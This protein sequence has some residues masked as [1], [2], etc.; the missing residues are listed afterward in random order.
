MIVKNEQERLGR[1]LQSVAAVADQ[2]VVVDTGSDDGT[3]QIAARHGAE[4]YEYAWREDFSAARNE[5]ISHARHEWILWLDADDVVPARSAEQ[6]K[7]LKGAHPDRVL[8]FIVRNQKP[9]D[10]G[11]EFVQARMFP[12]H[13]SLFFEGRIHEQIMPSA[14]RIGM[15]MEKQPVIIEHHGY[16]DASQLKQKARR[17]LR[18]LL[19]D[20]DP[21]HP[22]PV[23]IIEI[24]DSYT[25]LED[26]ESAR[27]WY[28]RLLDLPGI[29]TSSPFLATQALMGLGNL[30][31]SA[32]S[33]D[34]AID[35][36]GQAI[37]LYPDRPDV[38]YGLAV[39]YEMQGQTDRAIQAL[40][41]ILHIR[42]VPVQV[43]I[44]FRLT[45]VKAYLRLFRLCWLVRDKKGLERLITEAQ[46]K[47]ANRPDIKNA[48]ATACIQLG[49]L[50]DALHL[51][52][53]SLKLA[54]RGNIE[55]HIGLCVIYRKAS[56]TSLVNQTLDSIEP[57]FK[58]IPRY[59]AARLV[60]T[61][62]TTAE[63]PP[64]IDRKALGE[65]VSSLKETY[66]A[67]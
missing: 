63:I 7:S 1:C 50:M 32:G 55:A 52:E 3:R 25:I 64:G 20:F 66:A 53:E 28:G 49:R 40:Y 51:Y 46:E 6:L 59:W 27:Q 23:E 22:Q 18:Y 62:M 14:L 8:G 33:Y 29:K 36:F 35:C 16:A 12:N 58:D 39:S 57:L 54:Q 10:T 17:N 5:S 42:S 65:E 2:I 4:V 34:K 61:N 41:R 19:E 9:G 37:R 48:A 31:N 13:G 60:L 56:K 21:E 30:A 44:D 24:A 38:L 67:A 15:S 43:G 26:D 47:F 11:S 45:T